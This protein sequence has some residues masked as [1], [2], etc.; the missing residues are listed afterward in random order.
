M[1]NAWIFPGQGSQAL[2]MGKNL[3]ENFPCA[4]N[5][6]KEVD[7][8]LNQ[9]LSS[10]MWGENLE[11]LT[12][13]SNAQPAIMAVSFAVTRILEQEFGIKIENHANAVAGHSL[14]EYSALCSVKA[15]SLSDTAKLLRIRGDAMQSAVSVGEGAMAAILGGSLD[16]IENIAFE[17]AQG[18][19]CDI[20]NDNADGQVVVSGTKSAIERAIEIAKSKGIK[21]AMLLPVSAPF[22]C[23]LMKPAQEKMSEALSQAKISEPALPI[24]A[25]IK[26][27]P[28]S[29]T[30]KIREC[31]IEQVTGR[32][33]WRETMLN[34]SENGIK[35]LFEMG[36]GKVLSGLI[37]RIDKTVSSIS[38]GDT[39]TIK[40]FVVSVQS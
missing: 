12:L 22:H 2:G 3:A 24:Y 23:Q 9:N 27:S 6:F 40:S 25:N 34:M 20:A 36:H 38:I 28:I 4:A 7:D 30:D 29:S 39:E 33:R 14:G 26:A 17:A 10:I 31:L 35:S 37:K 13:T 32:V 15:L 8:A 21:R 18:E 16:D 19:I 1:A 11:E 5:V